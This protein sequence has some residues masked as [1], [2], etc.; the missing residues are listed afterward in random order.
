MEQQSEGSGAATVG[1]TP[2]DAIHKLE[3]DRVC[4]KKKRKSRIEG[5]LELESSRLDDHFYSI[6]KI[7]GLER[8]YPRALVYS[9]VS[10]FAAPITS[11]RF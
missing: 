7:N 9:F 3:R 1:D 5:I 4:D 11:W 10:W 8:Y 2:N 6:A